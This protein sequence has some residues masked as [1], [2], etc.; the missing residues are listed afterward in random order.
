MMI[1]PHAYNN[2]KA[3]LT[4]DKVLSGEEAPLYSDAQIYGSIEEG[5]GPYQFIN[6]VANRY[7]GAINKVLPVIMLR[8]W[9]HLSQDLILDLNGEE[10]MY[11]GGWSSDELASLLSLDMGIKLKPSSTTRF[12]QPRGDTDPEEDIGRPI[13]ENPYDIPQLSITNFRRQ[14]PN[15][16][17]GSLRQERVATYPSLSPDQA[18]ALVR[19]ARSYQNALWIADA[20]PNLA[21][22]LFVSALEAGAAYHSKNTKVDQ[23]TA[24]QATYPDLIKKIREN[25]DKVGLEDCI[26]EKLYEITKSTKK[27]L[28]F[29]ENFL[30]GAP[31]KRPA[32]WQQLKYEKEELSKALSQIYN[33]RSKALHTSTPFPFPMLHPPAV[34]A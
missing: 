33:Y 17:K 1:G 12:F 25:G 31:D 13:P 9:S 21:W 6:L 26:A 29:C 30:P 19:A 22:L 8:S 11:H 7:T 18:I 32:I 2:W 10:S 20:D 23:S 27:F 5:C 3:Y 34:I 14:L 4:G 24:L 28:L 15:L 16:N